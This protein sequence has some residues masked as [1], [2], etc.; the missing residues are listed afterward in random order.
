MALMTKAKV[1]FL[2]VKKS[3]NTGLPNGSLFEAWKALKEQY[4]PQ[5]V[6]SVQDVIRQ[7]QDCT[8]NA[9]ED[10]ENG[11]LTRMNSE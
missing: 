2:L 3:C 9:N 7:Y 10:P 1:A 4:E 11:L 6:E 5:G 8:L